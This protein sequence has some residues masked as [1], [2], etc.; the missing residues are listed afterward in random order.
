MLTFL[1]R[2]DWTAQQLENP[3]ENQTVTVTEISGRSTVR[4]DLPPAG[5]AILG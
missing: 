4:V 2:G 3:P 1:Y 5:M